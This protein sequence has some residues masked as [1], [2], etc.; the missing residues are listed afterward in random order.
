MS[1]SL[2][3]FLISIT[4]FYSCAEQQKSNNEP[5]TTK[6]ND[7]ALNESNAQNPQLFEIKTFEVKDSS[8]K[9]QGWGYDIY[10]NGSKSIHQPT[11][12]AISGIYSFKTEEDALKTGKFASDK[13]KSGGFLPTLS[14]AELDSLGVIPKN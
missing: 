10:V 2:L 1:K 8:G 9:S 13:M 6:M 12:P 14:I 4:L 7:Q 5:E 3:T 11:I